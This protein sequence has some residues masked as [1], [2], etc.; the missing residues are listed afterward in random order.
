MI[1][2]R[3]FLTSELLIDLLLIIELLITD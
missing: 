3:I 2:D 1:F